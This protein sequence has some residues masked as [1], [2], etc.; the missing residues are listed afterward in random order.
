MKH[1]SARLNLLDESEVYLV[2]QVQFPV[3][4]EVVG[5]WVELRSLQLLHALY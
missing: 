2:L 3:F 5:L 4:V 1:A